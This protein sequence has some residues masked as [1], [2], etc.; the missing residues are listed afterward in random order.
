MAVGLASGFVEPLEATSIGQMLEELRNIEKILID[1]RGVIGFNTIDSFNRSNHASWHGIC[2]FLRMHYDG[3]RQDTRFWRD[4]LKLPRSDRYQEL[5]ACFDHRL[6]RMMDIENYVGNG[7]APIFHMVNWLL[8]G[9]PLDVVTRRAG[10]SEL[11]GLPANMREQ[12]APYMAQLQNATNIG[13]NSI[14]DFQDAALVRQVIA[15]QQGNADFN[16]R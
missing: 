3:G 8:V 11:L 5:R 7:W 4:V 9:A 14:N 13:R 6:P 15:G 16:Q 1:G 10:A 12:M 2:D